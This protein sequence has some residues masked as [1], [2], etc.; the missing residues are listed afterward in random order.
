MRRLSGVAVLILVAGCSD[1]AAEPARFYP[2]PDR[3]QSAL[4][5]AL[6]AW[7]E[8]AAPGPVPGATHPAVECVDGQRPAGRKLVGFAVLGVA[9]GD[10]PRVFTVKLTFDGPGDPVRA[11]Y[12]VFGVDP[13]WVFR[14]EDYDMLNHWGHPMPKK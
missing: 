7:R 6:T 14:H 13:V 5:A 9:P 3:A 8:G 10:G 4:E 12:V 2:P 11:R 1:P